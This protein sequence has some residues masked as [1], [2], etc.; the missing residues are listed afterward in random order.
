MIEIKAI[1]GQVYFINIKTV[2]YVTKHL[3]E[4]NLLCTEIG[5]TGGKFIRTME[6]LDTLKDRI[7]KAYL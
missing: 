5:F 3:S 6:D 1:T 2:V 4:R 7:F